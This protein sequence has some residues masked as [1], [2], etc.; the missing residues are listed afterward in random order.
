MDD[1]LVVV[2]GGLNTDI[3]GLGFENLVGSGQIAY[4]E[5]LLIGPGGKSRNVAQMMAVLLGGRRVAMVGR[6][7]RDPFGLWVHP[8]RALEEAGVSTEF[9]KIAPFEESGKF[10]GVALVA[11]D[12]HGNNQIY[13]VPGANDDFSRQDIQDAEPAFEAAGKNGG[14]LALSLELPLATAIHAV[15]LAACHGLRVILD[16]GG[17]TET[18]PHAE[19]LSK[20]VFAIK[21]NEHEAQILTG[22]DVIDGA[23]AGQAAARL[24]AHGIKN[25]LITL[26]KD[27]AYLATEDGGCHI[28]APSIEA[29]SSRDATGCGDQVMAALCAALAGG[30]DFGTAARAAVVAGTLQFYKAGIVPV[31]A[32]ELDRFK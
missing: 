10:P 8:L 3:V 28:P 22:I 26:G 17:I 31:T 25:V 20:G 24:R 5:R 9:I 4:G 32:G 27:G 30:E 16:P 19:L 2:V 21:P 18:I 7:S 11:V 23:T 6:T 13:V 12:R 15:G 1:I 29:G 14:L